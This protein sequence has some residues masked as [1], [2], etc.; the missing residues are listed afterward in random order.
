MDI[1]RNNYIKQL[2][3]KELIQILHIDHELNNEAMEELILRK[4]E[5][6]PKYLIQPLFRKIEGV[7]DHLCNAST[8]LWGNAAKVLSFLD[9]K[10]LIP[11][12]LELLAWI[13]D[14]NDYGAETIEK[15]IKK[16]PLDV[17]IP[18]LEPYY[19]QAKVEANN[20]DDSHY[21]RLQCLFF[22]QEYSLER[23]CIPESYLYM[24]DDLYESWE[25]Q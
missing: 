24:Y 6:S 25:N 1:K 16:I 4:D 21:F 8:Y 22:G 7:N 17:L 2:G 20:G 15:V 14:S 18:A 12:I 19:L 11:H 23:K 3:L 9:T 10:K 13:E 5:L